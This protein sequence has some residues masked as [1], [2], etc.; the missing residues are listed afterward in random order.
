MLSL[1]ARSN[2]NKH[3]CG[4]LAII[5]RAKGEQTKQRR[6][7]TRLLSFDLGRGRHS[8]HSALKRLH[9]LH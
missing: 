6:C 9:L 2:Q 8:L 3:L 7:Q 4:A 1:C 5:A